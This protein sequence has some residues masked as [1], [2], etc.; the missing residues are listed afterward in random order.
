MSKLNNEQHKEFIHKIFHLNGVDFKEKETRDTTR[1]IW[2]NRGLPNMITEENGLD[3]WCVFAYGED[4][5]EGMDT[6]MV[7]E[8]D[9][10]N[11]IIGDCYYVCCDDDDGPQVVRIIGNNCDIEEISYGYYDD[12]LEPLYQR[13]D[14][15]HTL[16]TEHVQAY[17]NDLKSHFEGI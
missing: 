5:E 2:T 9:T 13:M 7:V 16:T 15:T 17:L 3:V 12:I 4:E 8:T 6:F 10:D 1:C 14:E 11:S